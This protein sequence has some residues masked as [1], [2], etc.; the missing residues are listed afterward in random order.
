MTNPPLPVRPP[1][2][3]AA[4]LVF[5]SL[6]G[7]ACALTLLYRGMRLVM[8]IGGSCGGAA[9]YVIA[10]PCPP[11]LVPAIFLAVLGGL[12]ALGLHLLLTI[13]GRLPTLAVLAWPALFLSLGWVFLDAG[14]RPLEG[15]GVDWG[16]LV[17]AGIFAAIGL[18]PAVRGVR[19]LAR[20]WRQGLPAPGHRAA[21]ERVIGGGAS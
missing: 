16:P 10:T 2:P 9:P 11:G 13:A 7:V 1:R 3:L 17:G 18:P 20:Q 4:L 14:I 19:T 21:R 5:L 12:A 8:E 15:G 6:A